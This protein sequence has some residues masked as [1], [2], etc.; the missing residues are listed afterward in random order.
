LLGEPTI[1][2]AIMGT[3]LLGIFDH[4]LHLVSGGHLMLFLA[5]TTGPFWRPP[6]SSS[7]AILGDYWH[8]GFG[9]VYVAWGVPP[10]PWSL[11]GFVW[12]Y[13]FVWMIAQDVVKVGIYREL[14]SR[15]K[16]QTPFLKHLKAVWCI[17]TALCI[18]ASL[19]FDL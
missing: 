5:K 18:S 19:R 7:Q 6:R 12:V 10:L 15:D 17:L 16:N 11:I 9:C 13:N 8:S 2:L 4:V 14:N 3:V 1:A